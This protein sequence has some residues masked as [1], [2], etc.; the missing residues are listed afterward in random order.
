M[1]QSRIEAY[2]KDE[3]II[4]YWYEPHDSK[5]IVHVTENVLVFI[6]KLVQHILPSNFKTIRHAG[7]YS[8]KDHKYREYKKRYN[9]NKNFQEFIHS[10]R[11]T[12][13]RDFK[14]DPLK[15]P[16]GAIMEFVD[17]FILDTAVLEGG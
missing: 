8:A 14:R 10:F 4:M 15:C 7:I 9:N 11:N 13:I 12:I 2:D 3:Q 6:G 5:E 1:A 17:I 16:C